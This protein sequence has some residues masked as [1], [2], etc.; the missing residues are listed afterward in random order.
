[1]F[2]V[3]FRLNMRNCADYSKVPVV[4]MLTQQF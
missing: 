3:R 1:M 2:A 4:F